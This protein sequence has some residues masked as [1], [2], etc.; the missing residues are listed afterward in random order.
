MA[1]LNL[2][3]NSRGAHVRSNW[4]SRCAVFPLENNRVSID[5]ATETWQGDDF[6]RKGTTPRRRQLCCV[7]S[8]GAN[9]SE[10]PQ[11]PRRIIESFV[12]PPRANTL[13]LSSCPSRSLL[14]LLF[15]RSFSIGPYIPSTRYHLRTLAA[16]L[17]RTLHILPLPYQV[18][19]DSLLS[20]PHSLFGLLLNISTLHERTRASTHIWS[21]RGLIGS[22]LWGPQAYLDDFVRLLS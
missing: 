5:D 20:L 13:F 22:F 18:L 17:S 12:K 9:P 3:L 1:K 4:Q 14:F 8:C 11:R 19:L 15:I 16:T 6:H 7:C 2:F 21:S 10:P